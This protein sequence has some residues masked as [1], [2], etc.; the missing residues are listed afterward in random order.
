MYTIYPQLFAIYRFNTLNQA[1]NVFLSQTIKKEFFHMILFAG[2]L[3]ARFVDIPREEIILALGA[4]NMNFEKL[5]V[6]VT[7]WLFELR[8]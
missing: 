6:V 4:K 3:V 8:V 7:H 5:N 1:S 2:S